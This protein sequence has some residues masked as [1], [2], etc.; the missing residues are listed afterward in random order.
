ME[1]DYGSVEGHFKALSKFSVP[2]KKVQL[3]LQRLNHLLPQYFREIEG[4]LLIKQ[5][6]GAMHCSAPKTTLRTSLMHLYKHQLK[7]KDLK[8]KEWSRIWRWGQMTSSSFDEI[9]KGKHPWLFW[10][11]KK[12]MVTKR[13]RFL[14][15]DKQKSMLQS[16]FP[17]CFQKPAAKPV[18][19]TSA[20]DNMP[21]GSL[22]AIFCCSPVALGNISFASKFYHLMLSSLASRLRCY[23]CCFTDLY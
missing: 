17:E 20:F 8:I 7:G 5:Q 3:K 4:D 22:Q 1:L 14:R 13:N 16:T 2:R 9:A 12:Y 10:K 19:R 21:A 18:A 15:L 23:P 11:G 6:Q